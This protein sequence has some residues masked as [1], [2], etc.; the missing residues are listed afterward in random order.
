MSQRRS[1]TSPSRGRRVLLGAVAVVVGFGLLAGA[2]VAGADDPDRAGATGGAADAVVDAGP[3][4]AGWA[5][6]NSP[7][8][9]S[10]TPSLFHQYNSSGAVNTITSSAV[11]VYR[12]LFPGLA[13]TGG[14][15]HVT[16]QGTWDEPAHCS[17]VGWSAVSG[18]EVVDVEC[19]A[20]GSTSLV[21][22]GFLVSFTNAKAGTFSAAVAYA[23]AD[24]PSTASYAPSRAYQ[25]NSNGGQITIKRSAA[26]IYDV[27]IPKMGQAGG[28]VKVSTYGQT[29]NRCLVL[30]W[31]P[32]ELALVAKV[33]CVTPGG[34][35][36]DT[37]FAISFLVSQNLFAH[38]L[39]RD[40]YVQV[41]KNGTIPNAAYSFNI[42]GGVNSVTRVDVGEYRVTLP[43]LATS[44]NGGTVQVS[45]YGKTSNSCRVDTWGPSGSDVVVVVLCAAAFGFPTNSDFTMQY[46]TTPDPPPP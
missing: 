8:S 12:V 1:S 44:T 27:R 29:T 3:W 37:Q 17:V 43:G 2:S 23:W 24:Q 13:R 32:K 25:F 18:D 46:A 35:G 31:A 40:G 33:R 5:W 6:A 42:T 30:R 4:A 11:G 16:A 14:V 19:R 7:S 28:S 41:D 39:L 20:L 10:Y 38:D 26:G 34:H 15:A 22:N 45:A 9:S 36:A 21:D